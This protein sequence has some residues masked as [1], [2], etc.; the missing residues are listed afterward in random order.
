MNG[1]DEPAIV[2]D[3]IAVPRAAVLARA[4]RAASGLEQL[5]CRE[6]DAIALLLRNDF[7]F[8]EALRAAS[9]IGVYA[10]P[11]NWH[12]S[13]DEILYVLQDAR[14]KVLVAHADLLLPLRARLPAGMQVLVVPTPA[15]VRARYGIAAGQGEPW[16]QDARWPDWC[17]RFPPWDGAPRASR[18]TLFYTSGT[19]GR[20]KGVLRRPAT[21]EQSRSLEQLMAEVYGFRP[22]IRALVC[23]PM[24]HAS[25]N[26][27]VRHA[28]NCA[29]VLVVQSRFDPEQTLAL[30]EKHR[31]CNA[32]MVPTMFI[33]LLKLPQAVRER[34]DIR[35]LKWVTHS[36]APCP[37]DIKQALM[38]W[39]GP[40]VYETYGGTETGAAT[41]STPR[42]WLAHPGSVGVA[43]TGARIV[44][45]GDDG[46]PVPDGQAGDVYMHVPAY[47][48]F[49]YLNHED[50]RAGVERDGLVTIGD[51]GYL[52]GGHLYLCDRRSDLVITGG[53]NVYP[54]EVEMVLA[55]CPGVQDCAVFGIPDAEFG[56][57][58][59][60]AVQLLPGAQVSAEEVRQYLQARLARYKV[61]RLVQF[62]AALPRE[63]SGKIFKR[64]L[65]APFWEGTGRN[66]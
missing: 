58:L 25:P 8:M 12:S 45:Y 49:T 1:M 53:A 3:D 17:D 22:G 54:A 61:P 30:I 64:R 60:A 47:A 9:A 57:S 31:I 18:S 56:E 43:T 41:L 36:G 66:I 11:L 20:P 51:I 46:Q 48:D 33:R 59:A 16:P 15:G 27:Y 23:G 32:V 13:A 35:S 38:D 62:H 4:G 55:D 63:D 29:D 19:T 65:R 26:V 6:G 42:D 24:Y 34:Y 40:I 28:L 21:A 2:L 14:P 37:R 10:I 7:A 44:V 5:S 52:Q 50:K 39:W